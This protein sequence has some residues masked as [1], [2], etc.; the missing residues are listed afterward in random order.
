MRFQPLIRI[1]FV[2]TNEDTSKKMKKTLFCIGIVVASSATIFLTCNNR[3]L[4]SKKNDVPTISLSWENHEFRPVM[5][6]EIAQKTEYIPLETSSECLVS[7]QNVLVATQYVLTYDLS[8]CLLFSRSG[9]FVGEIG[10]RGRGPGEYTGIFNVAFDEK[11]KIIYLNTFNNKIIAY[12][13]DGR[14]LAELPLKN[15]SD[16]ISFAEIIHWKDSLLLGYIKNNSGIEPYKYVI[17]TQ[18]GRVVKKIPQHVSYDMTDKSRVR[19][20][21][22]A[23][24]IYLFHGQVSLREQYEDTLFRLND[25]ITL[26]PAFVFDSGEEKT[27]MKQRFEPDPKTFSNYPRL[28]T[29]DETEKYLFIDCSFGKNKPPKPFYRGI[30]D[31][32]SKKLT[33][34]TFDQSL[35]TTTTRPWNNTVEETVFGGLLNDIDG[36]LPFALNAI[37]SDREAVCIYTPDTMMEFF[38]KGYDGKYVIKDREAAQNLKKMIGKLNEEDNPVIMIVTFK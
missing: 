2:Q 12:S 30:Y 18:T 15:I 8:R 13:T 11:Q 37:V 26:S 28:Y 1:I 14:L 27:P 29:V 5:L 21:T 24:D 16:G 7:G 9:K 23:E 36:G 22:S 35:K 4:T 17:F 31:K 32:E 19:S 6:S 3:S 10:K 38:N 33:Y 20:T 25:R 34:C